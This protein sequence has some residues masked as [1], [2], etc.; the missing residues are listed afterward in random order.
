VPNVSTNGLGAP[1]LI[2]TS[3]YVTNEGTGVLYRIT[4]GQVATV[5]PAGT[6]EYPHNVTGDPQGN[7]YVADN[8]TDTLY[9]I[10]PNGTITSL[11]TY[12]TPGPPPGAPT[13]GIPARGQLA[14]A[15]TFDVATRSVLMARIDSLSP[16]A[17]RLCS[18]PNSMSSILRFQTAPGAPSGVSVTSTGNSATVSWTAPSDQLAG[19]RYTV[20]ASPGGA[21]C[22]AVAPSTSCT[23]SGLSAM[24][25]YSFTVL[26]Q[27]AEGFGSAV[28]TG[29]AATGLAATGDAIKLFGVMG[30]FMA[31]FGLGLMRL[32]RRMLARR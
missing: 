8:G 24:T 23:V 7:L 26:A 28:G 17:R 20:T 6:F 12:G 10:S 27:S 13:R 22:T 32:R 18:P 15:L 25:T 31:G 21:T 29:T 2:G 4:D 9:L 14:S 3:L 16:V 5:V 19:D 30:L 1:A 11:G